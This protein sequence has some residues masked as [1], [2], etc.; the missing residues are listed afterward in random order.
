MTY[1]WPVTLR[2]WNMKLRYLLVLIFVWP[3]AAQAEI[4]KSVDA[5]GHVTY[6]STPMKGGKRV[7]LDPSTTSTYSAPVSRQRG[8]ESSRNFPR[9]DGA[10]Q[11]NRDDARRRILEEELTTE[12]K[13]L[14]EARKNL[15][16]GE[17]NPEVFRTPDGK[18]FRNVAKYQEKIKEL[19]DQVEVH[20]KNVEA[21]NTELS[22]LK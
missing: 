20:Q 7:I 19:T 22:K 3:M 8:E 6:S 15:K 14:A 4:Y 5:D 18:T 2:E 10:T 11:K 21:L 9:V 16:E 12:Q 17:A 1:T 13:L